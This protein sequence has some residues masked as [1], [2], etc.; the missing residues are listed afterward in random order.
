MKYSWIKNVLVILFPAALYYGYYGLQFALLKAAMRHPSIWLTSSFLSWLPA[1]VGVILLLVGAYAYV[2]RN[3][4]VFLA[5]FGGS[6]LFSIAYSLTTFNVLVPMKLMR[7]TNSIP[8]SFT[9]AGVYVAAFWMS[10][11]CKIK[12]AKQVAPPLPLM[13]PPPPPQPR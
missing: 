7:M 10:L 6:L 3:S 11:I 2:N 12:G 4:F 1:I 13:T 5:F 9:V 8:I